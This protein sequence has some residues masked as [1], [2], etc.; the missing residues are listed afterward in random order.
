MNFRNFVSSGV[1]KSAGA[2]LRLKGSHASALPGLI[3]EK[4]D[5]RFLLRILGTLPLGVAVI[6]GTN[7]KTTTTKMVVELL[8]KNGL[9]VFTNDSGS[10]WARGVASAAAQKMRGGQ[11][12]F[13]IAVLELDEAHAVKFVH[14]IQ[15]RFALLLNVL[16]DQLDR[17]GEI[18]TTAKM[19]AEIAKNT[20]NQIVLNANDPRIARD[21]KITKAAVS[22]FGFAPKLA[23][24]FPTDEQLHDTKKVTLEQ[25]PARHSTDKIQLVDFDKQSVAQ[26]A[27]AGQMISKKL[28]AG[29]AHNALNGA[30]ALALVKVILTT[31]TAKKS[32]RDFDFVRNCNLLA[33]VQPAFGRGETTTIGGRIVSLNL[34]KNPAGFQSVLRG[35]DS[36]MPT[37][38]LVND[39][40]A[41]GRDVSWLYDVDFRK[42]KHNSTVMTG[43]VRAF[44]IALRLSYDDVKVANVEP[45]IGV[46]LKQ[47]LQIDSS[48][49]QIFATYTAMLATRQLLTK[50]IK[51]GENH[52]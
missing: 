6:S 18:D 21:E 30:A 39:Q 45:D 51:S 7:G 26:Y 46:I 12:D 37:L 52:D 38:F 9:R 49:V 41:D 43:G 16:R 42:F 11:L 27:L 48:E 17:F 28:S 3:I 1:G 19:L 2:L 23:S 24:I 4:I 44:D 14:Q 34:V 36:N 29:G 40:Y 47:F 31:K 20:T 35:A 25:T 10:N 33:R 8:E 22:W 5:P 15:P 13:D 32:P 50:Y